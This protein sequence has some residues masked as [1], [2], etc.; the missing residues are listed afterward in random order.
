[1]RH[2]QI[3][4]LENSHRVGD[5]SEADAAG[6]GSTGLVQTQP[7]GNGEWLLTPSGFVGAAEVGD[8]LLDIQPKDRV[9][10][11][12]LLFL[13]GYA[14]N[15]GF[16]PEDVAGEG[17]SD[18]WSALAESF[19][20]QCEGALARG[21]LHGYV[22][23]DD[24]LRTVRGRIR[25]ADQISRRPGMLLPLEVTYDDH[26]TDIAENRILRAALR[27][28]LG[29]KRVGAS[30]RQRLA[31]LD[32]R[33]DG[34]ELLRAGV[35]LPRWQE[36]RLNQR[37]VPALRLA[38]IIL[39]NSAAETKDGQIRVASF[40]VNMA[41]VFEDFV[42]VAL[43]EAVVELGL[44]GRIARQ[45]QT[46]LDEVDSGS[47]HRISM[48]IDSVYQ[49]ADIP[50]VVFDA[51]YKVASNTGNYANADHYQMLAYCT[52]LKATTAWLVFA[53][54]GQHRSLRIVNTDVTVHEFPLDV[55]THPYEV[56][57]RVRELVELSV[58]PLSKA[59]G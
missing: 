22:S 15:P 35:P 58:M 40:K 19:A 42:E 18:L 6:L 34:V 13:L 46:G 26:T 28:L 21:V 38:E 1:M 50:S 48:N 17:T 54:A 8:I 56:L 51:K 33:L 45:F 12:Q 30:A 9:G 37:Y 4:E 25:M 52:A 44:P 36:S 59:A 41:K 53:G 55:S 10:V 31:H 23:V 11:S 32:R 20:R 39:D 24:A 3:G 7:I 2:I 5:L 14:R 29:L 27:R 43:A 47:R 57:K 49:T 16:R